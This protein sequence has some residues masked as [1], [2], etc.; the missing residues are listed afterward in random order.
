MKKSKS[1]YY[2]TYV[3]ILTLFLGCKKEKKIEIINSPITTIKPIKIPAPYIPDAGDTLFS[4]G[5]NP[6]TKLAGNYNCRVTSTSRY[7]N[8][9]PTVSIS[10]RI[11]IVTLENSYTLNID[12]KLIILDQNGYATTTDGNQFYEV[13]LNLPNIRIYKSWHSLGGSSSIESVGYKL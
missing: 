1:S 11:I 4:I 7:M 5:I 13:Q 8:N 2:L 12:G 10:N 9:P 3:F 6:L